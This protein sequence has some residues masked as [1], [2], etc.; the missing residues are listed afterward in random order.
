MRSNGRW[1]LLEM[2][3]L[4]GVGASRSITASAAQDG[5]RPVLS[6]V[7]PAPGPPVTSHPVLI[8][9]TV[10]PPDPELRVTVNGQP[11]FML[12][13]GEWATLWDLPAGTHGLLDTRP[14]GGGAR[15]RPGG[16]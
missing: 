2:A 12:Q 4:L 3:V 16:Q 6:I 9:G 10:E 5:P 8:R 1:I 13:G 11:T 7:Y 14:A 15:A